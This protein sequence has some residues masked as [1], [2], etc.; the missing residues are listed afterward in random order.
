MIKGWKPALAAIR[1]QTARPNRLFGFSRCWIFYHLNLSTQNFKTKITAVRR[2][3]CE[4]SESSKRLRSLRQGPD[5]ASAQG[6]AD[7]LPI[8][9]NGNLLQV[10]AKGPAGST[11]GEAAIVTKGCG[12]PTSIALC[13]CLNPFS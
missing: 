4:E 1:A 8:F 3:S 11:L 9:H 2:D 12:F 6:L 10:R 5:A 7:Q 13:H